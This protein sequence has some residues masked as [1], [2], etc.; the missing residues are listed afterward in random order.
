MSAGLTKADWQQQ[1][2][3]VELRQARVE[4]VSTSSFFFLHCSRLNYLH[5]PTVAHAAT[6]TTDGLVKM[7]GKNL[8]FCRIARFGVNAAKISHFC[9]EK[10][11]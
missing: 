7:N 11:K 9:D 10:N 1:Q 5:A 4:P 2:H 6:P 8:H 3:D